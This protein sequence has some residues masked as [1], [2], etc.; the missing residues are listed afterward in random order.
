M[1]SSSLTLRTRPRQQ[2]EDL[3]PQLSVLSLS[4]TAVAL[5]NPDHVPS[6]PR[7]LLAV[8]AAKAAP[9]VKILLASMPPSEFDSPL[10]KRLEKSFE[11]Y[12]ATSA[13]PHTLSA[14]SRRL[15]HFFTFAR[16]LTE[17]Q[18]RTASYEECLANVTICRLWLVSLA[19][20]KLGKTVVPAA[21]TMLQT[22]RELTHPAG[23][24]SLHHVKAI[25][26]LLDSIE[27]NTIS[28]D[29]QAPGLTKTHITLILRAWGSS[30]RWDEVMMASLL[31]NG[32]QAT[33]RPIEISCLGSQAVWWIL[34]NGKEVRSNFHRRPPPL[35]SVRGI[36]MALLPRK[37]RQGQ[38]SY[39]PAPAGL[40]V[41]AMW[42]HANNMH[43]LCPSAKFFFPSRMHPV[44]AKKYTYHAKANWVPNPEN[45][46][47]QTSISNV[48]IPTALYRCCN[49]PKSQ[50]KIF[51]GYSLRVGGTT[52]HEEAGTAESVRRNLAE[53][54]SLATARHYLQHS[55]ATQFSFLSAAAI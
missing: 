47:S 50:S 4:L 22:H 27:K 38:M 29:H 33:L 34:G 45:P 26:M 1:P 28:R 24:G 10:A 11:G 9:A 44:G 12:V 7:H 18:G 17:H 13:T 39:V 49:I 48:A 43:V 19:D 21:T 42:R 8:K 52:H 40:V 32:F 2:R 36:I 53:W 41:S 20:Q 6:T 14:R 23:I 51:T 15:D 25:K 37:N 3:R 5:A 55:P 35:R 54:M 30:D 46:F 16:V 31:G